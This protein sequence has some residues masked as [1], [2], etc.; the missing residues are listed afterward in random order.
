MRYMQPAL[1]VAIF[2]VTF[3]LVESQTVNSPSAI[4]GFTAAGFATGAYPTDGFAN[5]NEFSGRLNLM[6]PLSTV[7]GR[8]DVRIPLNLRIEADN[9]IVRHFDFTNPPFGGIQYHQ[10]SIGRAGYTDVKKPIFNTGTIIA[11]RSGDLKYNTVY[12]GDPPGPVVTRICMTLSRVTFLAPDGSEV[13]LRDRLTNGTKNGWNYSLGDNSTPLNR[14]RVFDSKD[15][16]LTTFVSDTDVVDPTC[17]E[18][19]G[20]VYPEYLSGTLYLANGVTYRIQRTQIQNQI[21]TNTTITDRNGNKTV[22]NRVALSYG[23]WETSTTTITDSIGRKVEIVDDPTTTATITEKGFGSQDRVTTVQYGQAQLR[24]D[25]QLHTYSELF[26]DITRCGTANGCG[27]ATSAVYYPGT[28]INSVTLP[29]GRPYQF[30]YNSY[31]ELARVELPTGGAYEYDYTGQFGSWNNGNYDGPYGEILMVWSSIGAHDWAISRRVAKQRTYNQGN[32]L[33]SETIYSSAGPFTSDLALEVKTTDGSGSLL[34]RRI[35]YFKGHPLRSFLP[36]R[37]VTSYNAEF[38]GRALKVEIYG[39]NG[40]LLRVLEDAWEQTGSAQKPENERLKETKTTLSDS[41]QVAKKSFSYDGFNRVTDT[42]EY[43]Y[44][45]GQTGPLLRRT[46]TDYLTVN[47]VNNVD[48]TGENVR[49]FNLPSQKWISSDLSGNSKMSLSRFEYDNYSGPNRAEL[50]GRYNVFGFDSTNYGIANLVRGNLTASTAYANAQG[51]TGLVTTYTHYDV[52]GNA[53][54]T[55]DPKGY[56]STV[57]YADRFGS[58]DGEARSNTPPMQLNGESSFAYATAVTNSMGWISYSQYDYFLGQ[59]VNTED[60]NGMISKM[61]YDDLLNR[62]TQTT[63]AVG[64]ALESQSTIFYDDSHHRTEIK[65]DLISLAD[66]LLRSEIYYDGFG[67]TIESRRYESGE[68]YTATRSIP[69]ISVQDPVTGEWRVASKVSNPFRPSSDEQPVWISTLVDEFGRPSRVVTPEGG[70]VKTEYLGS[71]VTTTDPAGKKTRSTT[72][73]VGWVTRVDE[74]NDA[75]QLD[76][77]GTPVQPTIYSYDV[78]NNLTTVRQDGETTGQ[79]GGAPPC[80]QIRAFQYDSLSRLILASN[81]ETGIIQYFYDANG[82][83]QKRT[84][85]RGVVTDFLYDGLNRITNKNYSTPNGSPPNY[86][87]TQNVAYTYDDVAVPNSRGRLTRVSNGFS[88]TNYNEFDLLDRVKKSSQTTDGV[89]YGTTDTPMTYTYNLMGALTEQQ[90]PSGR[91]VKHSLSTDG[92][93][94]VQSKRVNDNFRN[95]G[96]AFLYSAAGTIS[97]M[98][99]GNGKW[100]STQYN[101]R[102]QPTQIGLGGSAAVTNLLRLN[103]DYGSVQNNGSLLS[104][105]ITVPTTTA[106]AGFVINQ[107]Y[108]YDSL[109]RLTQAVE[110]ISNQLPVS[111][112]Q[113]FKY[114]RYGNRSFDPANTTTMPEGCSPAVCNPASDPG[115]NKLVGSQF[116]AS[117]NMKADGSGQIFIYDG[118]NR[119]VEVR[120]VAGQTVALYFY[121]GAGRRV[122]KYVVPSGSDPGETT[123]FVYDASGKLIAEHSTIVAP[124]QTAKTSYLTSDHLGSVRI[125]TDSYGQVIS[126]RD[127]MPFGESVFRGGYGSDSVRQKFTGYERDYETNLDYAKARMYGSGVGRFTSP[128]PTLASTKRA[129]PQSWNRY[130]YALNNPSKY[131]DPS[132]MIWGF[133]N[134]RNGGVALC[135]A[136]GT[137]VCAG[138]TPI[139]EDI[140]V[141]DFRVLRNGRWI[142]YGSVMLTTDSGTPQPVLPIEIKGRGQAYIT[143]EE[144]AVINDI[145]G[146]AL[147]SLLA[148]FVCPNAGNPT[149]DNVAAAGDIIQ[150]VFLIKSLLKLGLSKVV[151]KQLYKLDPKDV[152]KIAETV[153]KDFGVLECVGCAD[154][155][156]AAFKLKGVSGEV[157]ELRSTTGFIVSETYGAG[158]IISDNGFH[159]A[160]KIGDQV[161]DNIHKSGIPYAEWL[162]DFKSAG[163]ITVTPKPF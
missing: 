1:L 158:K 94:Q 147:C 152:T 57:D 67:R 110:N 48:Y 42:F 119:Q 34:N 65:K 73:A 154:A 9:L 40:N 107:A 22:I 102:L 139:R 69:F 132:G 108:S 6:L 128:D 74:P 55:I 18:L 100:E 68:N 126:R 60:A 21:T 124:T 91:V 72:N 31:G 29:D 97:A 106:N 125:I 118:E 105:T 62:P 76:V 66:N 2:F 43:D 39:I 83:L 52:L 131:V 58:P 113:S 23:S 26:P 143:S 16:S 75:G 11:R 7:G 161:F 89:V 54:K 134:L 64:T 117:G 19:A 115:T 78:L 93:V 120:D 79:C 135:Y 32:A 96:N 141:H 81:P 130:A 12:V 33:E 150:S 44:G 145:T 30:F 159:K 28:R 45:N 35:V 104:Q 151:I 5:V 157:L 71:T 112:K 3:S 50:L 24:A 92:L 8:G 90:Y 25:Q 46:H 88:V 15:G 149:A 53:V 160:V 129:V 56:P 27:V 77:G 38:E 10:Y 133:I 138:Y 51:E 163:S 142:N 137:N 86:Q 136:P 155:L 111:W 59:A 153:S 148:G 41:G 116:D 146:G 20:T 122:K 61:R 103:Y 17:S 162:K 156:E 144:A 98:R 87:P 84:D 95:Y 13:E 14:G 114:D 4:T 49:L 70:V 37:E 85:A 123:H 63:V 109:N 99:L 36:Y 47:P 82:N 80:S 101:F 127:F 140:V 121:D